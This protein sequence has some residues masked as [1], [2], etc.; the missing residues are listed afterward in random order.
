MNEEKLKEM[1]KPN[2]VGRAREFLQQG[3][4]D[5]VYGDNEYYRKGF[6]DG[7]L[8]ADKHP[9]NPWV[10]DRMPEIKEGGWSDTVLLLV[11]GQFLKV[12]RYCRRK[13]GTTY[14]NGVQDWDGE[15][16]D[17]WMPIPELKRRNKI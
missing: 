16:V 2:K 3:R 17:A 14:W 9:K 12:S 6:L 7:G 13:D 8:Y 11:D 15:E 5:E 10:T 1:A 4:K